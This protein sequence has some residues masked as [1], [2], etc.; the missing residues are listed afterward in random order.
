MVQVRIHAT[1]DGEDVVV[2]A[3]VVPMICLPPSSS[4]VR[5]AKHRYEH[6]ANLNLANDPD[7]H[8]SDIKIAMLIG[9]DHYWSIILDEIHRG[10]A[11]PGAQAS[12][13][14]WVLS[15]PLERG[16]PD[17]VGQALLIQGHGK[18]WNKFH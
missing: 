12:R 4:K 9:A 16:D 3:S 6:L 18:Y 10:E 14:G 8:T 1:H 2:T 15:G 11:G 5:F 7:D 13:C 17:V